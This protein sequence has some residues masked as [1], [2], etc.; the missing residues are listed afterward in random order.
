VGTLGSGTLQELAAY[1][2]IKEAT[3]T[4]INTGESLFGLEEGFARL[5][6]TTPWI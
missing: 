5:L 1:K 3:V 4:P 6:R 2:E